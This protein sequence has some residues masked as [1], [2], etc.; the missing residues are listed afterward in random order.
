MAM[1]SNPHCSCWITIRAAPS[2]PS[3]I[4]LGHHSGKVFQLLQQPLNGWSELAPRCTRGDTGYLKGLAPGLNELFQ[5]SRRLLRS[6]G[7]DEALSG[8]CEGHVKSPRVVAPEL[9][10]FF[11]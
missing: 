10:P 3:P 8:A 2:T 9:G 4:Y 11:R 1:T 7:D 5:P 6:A